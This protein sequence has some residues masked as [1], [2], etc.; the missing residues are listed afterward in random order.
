V[1]FKIRRRPRPEAAPSEP[2]F[3]P[4]SKELVGS[5]AAV[6]IKVVGES[7]R[8][9][10]LRAALIGAVSAGAFYATDPG[11]PVVSNPTG[12]APPAVSTGQ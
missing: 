2:I 8:G 9:K 10:L 3:N 5:I 4:M 1:R 12:A 11:A 6:L 7:V